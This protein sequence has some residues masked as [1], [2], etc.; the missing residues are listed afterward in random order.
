MR[1]FTQNQHF[2]NQTRRLVV[3]KTTSLSVQKQHLYMEHMMI[4]ET[5][6]TITAAFITINC[7]DDQFA[8]SWICFAIRKNKI[9][10]HYPCYGS[11]Y[12]Q[13]R[14]SSPMGI[15][16]RPRP[17]LRHIRLGTV[18]Q[19]KMKHCR[20]HMQKL[21]QAKQLVYMHAIIYMGH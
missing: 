1:K 19:H 2:K 16:G 5:N 4:I 11:A 10:M 14:C 15:P 8:G 12:L 9:C 7:Q 3:L 20:L 21:L 17:T 13:R 18:Q 6:I